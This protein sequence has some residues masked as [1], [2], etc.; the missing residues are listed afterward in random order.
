MKLKSLVFALLAP[1]ALSGCVVLAVADTAA[2]AVVKT[3]GLVVD[4]AVGAAKLT[5]KAV[6]AAADLVIP[7]GEEEKK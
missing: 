1:L 4:G 6:G 3:G 7:D 5:G 2:T